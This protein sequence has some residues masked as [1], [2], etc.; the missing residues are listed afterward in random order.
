ML[1]RIQE[2]TVEVNLS[3]GHKEKGRLNL[4]KERLEASAKILANILL[5]Y[6]RNGGNMD[7]STPDK[8]FGRRKQ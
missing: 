5:D 7:D 2:N 4:P 6:A 8:V 3:T 1:K